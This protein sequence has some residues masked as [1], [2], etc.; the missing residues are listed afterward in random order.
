[1]LQIAIPKCCFF[2]FYYLAG[3]LGACEA[4][5]PFSVDVLLVFVAV[6]IRITH[7]FSD[8]CRRLLQAKALGNVTQMKR[9]DVENVL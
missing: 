9:L 5:L 1:M 7:N 8:V 2:L 4:V 6:N 3:T